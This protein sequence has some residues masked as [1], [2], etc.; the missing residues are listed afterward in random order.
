M[1]SENEAILKPKD[2]GFAK[3]LYNSEKGEVLGRTGT[4]WLKITVFFI[5]FYLCLAGFFAA[6]LAVF[7]QTLDTEFKPTYTPGPG[8]SILINPAL[9]F[10]PRPRSENVE[11]SLIWYHRTDPEDIEH[12]TNELN[13]FTEAYTQHS[14]NVEKCT[15]KKYEMEKKKAGS[16]DD[17]K[18]CE[19]N[20]NSLKNQCTPQKEWGYKQN[21][22]CILLKMN[23]MIDWEPDVYKSLSELPEDMPQSL[24][25]E[26]GNITKK[27]GN[28]PP[29]VWLNCEGEYPADQEYIPRIRYTPYPGFPAYYFPYKNV[30]DYKSPLVGVV[31]DN[32]KSNVLINVECRL[33]AKNILI[34]R[35]ERLGMIHFELLID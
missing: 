7:Y 6:M 35:G 30:A 25:E 27:Y 20:R 16:G 26:I 12:W 24:K 3:F 14:G 28:I 29:V 15:F 9:G 2:V 18:V 13:E 32:P 17:K 19:F 4:S 8:G 23:R 1:P 10:R 22:P 11:S 34:E 33:W 21:T 31:F 5:F